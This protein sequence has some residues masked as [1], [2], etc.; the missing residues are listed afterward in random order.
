MSVLLADVELLDGRRVDVGVIGDRIVGVAAGLDRDRFD[1][2]IDGRA[3]ALIPGLYDHHV[4]LLAAAAALESVRCGPPDVADRDGLAARLRAARPGRAG[5]IRG[6]GYHE[7]VM[8]LPDA[9]ALDALRDDC[10]IRIQH[11]SGRLWLFNHAALGSLRAEHDG[12]PGLERDPLGSP[13]GRLYRS[14]LWLRGRLP[15]ALPDLGPLG[16]CL[17]A[18]GVTGVTDA[19]ATN[20]ATVLT[21][22]AEARVSGALRCRILAMTPPGTGSAHH[23]GVTIGPVKVVV[24]E[25]EDLDIDRVVGSIRAARADGRAVAFHCATLAELVVALSALGETQTRPG[26]R[27][28]HGGVIPHELVGTLA[29]QDLIVVTQP[30]FVVERGDAYLEQVETAD[31][32][33][34]FPCRRLLEAGVALA[35]GSDA[36][37]G[38]LDPWAAIAGATTRRTRAGRVL[39]GEETISTRRAL[40]LFLGP[41]DEPA[42]PRSVAVGAPADLCLL[43]VGVPAMLAAPRAESVRLTLL[44]GHIVHGPS[45][46]GPPT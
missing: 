36:P 27:I 26:D 3:G 16:R 15:S 37:F 10:P 39:G 20:D 23:H 33:D 14:D 4:H 28:E 24:D 5:W 25:S 40:D 46:P 38:S 9:D 7:S 45:E 18:F 8:G 31:R 29:A 1:D 17:A 13:T 12:P 35:A 22:L 32:N 41:A 21:A 44:G 11:R 43:S 30:S 42:R 34:L 2:V 6:V 19:T